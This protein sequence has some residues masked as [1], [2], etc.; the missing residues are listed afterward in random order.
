MYPVLFRIGSFEVTSFGAMMAVAALVGLWIFRRELRRSGCR[1]RLWTR[2]SPGSSAGSSAPSCSGSPSTSGEDPV[3]ALLF[4]R[5][6]LSWFGGLIGGVGAG[7]VVIIARGWP[8]VATLAAATPALAFGHAIGR[9]GCFLV[10]DDYGRAT[11]R[12]PWRFPR[13][14]RQPPCPFIRR[15]LRGHRLLPIAAVLFRMRRRNVVD[16]SVVGAY[17][18]MTA[19]VRF[20][21]QWSGSTSRLP[22][23]WFRPHRGVCHDFGSICCSRRQLL[24]PRARRR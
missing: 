5:G 15:G 16:R 24:R 11:F 8:I 2:A 10:G 13:G 6:G 18:V 14:C 22:G 4:A 12:G 1:T 17:L 7:L 3:T 23:P 9:I 21:I 19:L 20:L